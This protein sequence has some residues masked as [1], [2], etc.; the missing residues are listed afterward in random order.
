M[1]WLRCCSPIHQFF[2]REIAIRLLWC[3]FHAGLCPVCWDRDL[4]RY[5]ESWLITSLR[6]A[7]HDVVL[8]CLGFWEVQC[9]CCQGKQS[10]WRK[11][12]DFFGQ[13]KCLRISLHVFVFCCCFG[14]CNP[15]CLLSGPLRCISLH[16]PSW[17]LLPWRALGLFPVPRKRWHR[18]HQ[19]GSFCCP[20]SGN[21]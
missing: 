11:A 8:A 21:L 10:G 7:Q 2:G 18:C 4:G 15:K 14:Y 13:P 20:C 5:P 3:S 17:W 1:Q 6:K 12:R 16:R 9:S 19:C